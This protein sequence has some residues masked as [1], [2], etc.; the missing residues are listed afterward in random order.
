MKLKRKRKTASVPLFATSDIAFL[1][2]IFI[3]LV[4]LINHRQ[5]VAI[6]FAEAAT[7]LRTSAER[8]LEVWVDI[9]GSVYLD[10][11]L[12]DHA[13]LGHTIAELNATAPDTRVHVI[14]DRNVT[15]DK[16]NSVLEILQ[17]LQ[18][19]LVS[20]VVKAYE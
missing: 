18:Y 13:A 8:N 10:G 16:I 5:E 6:D 9:D 1:L 20:F 3:M 11:I 12:A 17:S 4:S 19:R 7:A 15:Y 14:A 2:L